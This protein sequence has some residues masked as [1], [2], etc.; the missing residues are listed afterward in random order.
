VYRELAPP[1][2]LLTRV[3]C[4]WTHVPRLETATRGGSHERARSS[5]NIVPDTCTDIMWTGSELRVAGPDTRPV[6]ETAPGA[7][8]VGLRF[9][10]GS[11]GSI[12]G[13]P[14]AALRDARVDLRALWGDPAAR[15]SDA[16]HGCSETE[17]LALLQQAV[18]ARRPLW[19]PLEKLLPAL[20]T[21]LR[22]APRDPDL[23]MAG[24]ARELGLSERQLQRRCVAAVGYAPKLLARVQRM[25][26]FREA[27]RRE[28]AR[29]LSALAYELG[30]ADQ[31]HLSHESQQLFGASPSQ[32]R[33]QAQ[34]AAS[35]F[36]KTPERR[37]GQATGHERAQLSNHAAR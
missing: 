30:F 1:T 37:V 14:L 33:K 20:L 24:V 2:E 9:H 29:P 34:R 8:V 23:R 7:F 32:L 16:L 21:A 4:A 13:T 36:D 31:A 5:V 28:P 10:C 11:G 22:R 12:L 15:L 35:D 19:L 18:L 3:R 27:L 17:A 6:M 25:L 26:A